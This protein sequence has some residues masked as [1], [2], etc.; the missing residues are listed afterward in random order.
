MRYARVPWTVLGMMRRLI[1]RG[2]GKELSILCK[3][4]VFN[5]EYRYLRNKAYLLDLEWICGILF[6]EV[7]VCHGPIWSEQY[8]HPTKKEP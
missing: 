5:Y 4:V 6:L 2:L 1:C 8:P 3:V 7:E